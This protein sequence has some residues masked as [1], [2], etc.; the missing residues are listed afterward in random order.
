M[1]AK[2]RA[3]QEAVPSA[4]KRTGEISPGTQ[5]RVREKFA[6]PQGWALKWDGFGLYGCSSP[7]A[8]Q[9][10]PKSPTTPR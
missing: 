1:N 8:R 5:H 6:E 3:Q 2:N 4:G 10:A 7:P 9:N